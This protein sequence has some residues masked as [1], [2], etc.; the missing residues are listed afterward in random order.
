[1][2]AKTSCVKYV[3]SITFLLTFNSIVSQN[4][5]IPIKQYSQK[6]K[7][8]YQIRANHVIE[9]GV[10]MAV[11]NGDFQDPL[12][13]IYYKGGYKHYIRPYLGLG[14]SYHK[15]N[16]AYKD[17]FN[18]GYM[19]FD[20][21]LEWL[22]LPNNRFSPYLF[23]G[24]GY[25]AANYFETTTTKTQVGIGIEYI[26]TDKIGFTL[27]SDYN[28]VFD[29]TLDG[30]EAGASDDTYFRIGFGVNFYF[31]KANK[32]QRYAEEDSEINSNLIY[33]VKKK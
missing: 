2:I 32:K 17:E 20:L 19:S 1:M 30:L 29:D 16:L 10:G 22:T 9:T 11:I 26:V 18:F 5:T 27:F 3:A 13:E 4:D 8:F 21:N 28:Y 7:T 25:N 33:P 15:F 24:I 23:W 14:L 12:F 6:F 31:G